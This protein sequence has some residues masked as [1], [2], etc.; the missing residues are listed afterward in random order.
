MNKVEK[1]EKCTE[2]FNSLIRPAGDPWGVQGKLDN[3]FPEF[4]TPI[5]GLNFRILD[6]GAG[7]CLTYEYLKERVQKG[8]LYW[9]GINKGGDLETSKAKGY[10]VKDMDFNFLEYEDNSFDLLIAVSVLEHSICP[11][12]ML[13]EMYRVASKYVFV[14]FPAINAEGGILSYEENPDHHFIMNKAMWEKMFKIV[15]FSIEKSGLDGGE[16]QYLLKK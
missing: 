14:R 13:M 8:E 7:D 1:I 6:I 12:L 11:P 9:E 16:L 2:L 4:L 10:N 5:I 3:F 15:G